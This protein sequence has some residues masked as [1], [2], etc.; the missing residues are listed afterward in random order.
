MLMSHHYSHR[1]STT[2]HKLVTKTSRALHL[3]AGYL[4]QY[5]VHLLYSILLIFTVM[6]FVLDSWKWY[7]CFYPWTN[8]AF[9]IIALRLLSTSSKTP[10]FAQPRVIHV[11]HLPDVPR[12]A[13]ENIPPTWP[14]SHLIGQSTIPCRTCKPPQWLAYKYIYI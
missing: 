11:L 3:L 12:A 13:L 4:R 9:M 10:M 5:F 1:L 14:M 6:A 7:Y 8:I 2:N